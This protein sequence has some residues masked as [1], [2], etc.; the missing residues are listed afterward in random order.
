MRAAQLVATCPA[1]RATTQIQLK[2]G[3]LHLPVRFPSLLS[4]NPPTLFD[5]GHA[6]RPWFLSCADRPRSIVLPLG[7]VAD[8]PLD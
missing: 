2:L 3:F 7:R 5:R 1:S 6:P 4:V 8:H